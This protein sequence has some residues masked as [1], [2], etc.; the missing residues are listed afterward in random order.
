MHL[1]GRGYVYTIVSLSTALLDSLI[2]HIAQT[3]IHSHA[4]WKVPGRSFERKIK[5]FCLIYSALG[6]SPSRKYGWERTRLSFFCSTETS[7]NSLWALKT[8][9]L[10]ACHVIHKI[11]K[12]RGS[13]SFHEH[14]KHYNCSTAQNLNWEGTQND[15][16]VL[17]E[18]KP[19]EGHMSKCGKKRTELPCCQ[20]GQPV[21][22]GCNH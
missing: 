11:P 10:Q 19:E 9:K 3:L 20:G 21:K 14:T 22:W 6:I 18:E 15:S 4:F 8:Q 1:L 2:L 16:Y 7:G 5:V 13:A 17:G 12:C